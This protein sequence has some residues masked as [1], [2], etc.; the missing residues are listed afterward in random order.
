MKL[1]ELCVLLVVA[2]AAGEDFGPNSC[3]AL[4]RSS[5]G[6]CVISTD[7]QGA[8]ITQTEFAFDCVNTE[9][10]RH[11]FG[12]GGFEANEEF[13]T[14]VKCAR[15]D[16]PTGVA[17]VKAG[18]LAAAPVKKV[19]ALRKPAP[20]AVEAP[21]PV[22]Q[23]VAVVKPVP[24]VV[25]MKPKAK[26]EIVEATP[27]PL[28]F[29]VPVP[30]PKEQIP[31]VVAMRAAMKTEVKVKAKS[32]FWPFSKGGR[33]RKSKASEA[34][35]YG[36]DGCVSTY[37][38]EEGH[39]IMSTDC[40]KSNVKDYQFGLV[41]VDKTGSPVKHLFG[42]DSFD[43][44]ET[45]DTLIKCDKCLG[46]ED[47]PD[48]I[49]LAG[50]VATMAKDVASITAVMKNISINVQMLNKAVFPAA[51]APGPAAAGSP[52]PA[53]EAPKA[54]KAED[55]PVDDAPKVQLHQSVNHHKH[56][57]NLRR[58]HKHHHHH[59][60][61]HHRHEDEDDDDDDDERDDD[62]EVAPIVAA[63][64]SLPPN[65]FV[66]ART[67]P[68]LEVVAHQQMAAAS[69][70]DDEEEEDDGNGEDY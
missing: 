65:A 40:G 5:G 57:G 43:S 2:S 18:K 66:A 53:M 42:K 3:V 64:Q 7:C 51:A 54:K 32:G 17:H 19:E 58:S 6:S 28:A 22:V 34:V 31:G 47:I 27:A 30:T 14:E 70:D 4:T 56:H 12:V 63:A 44:K 24:V 49:A 20:V 45:F 50:E 11:S 39:C 36:P 61:R 8:D 48:D 67:A 60:R 33:R 29:A 25:A 23:V 55:A 38:S 13:D 1:V 9:V 68:V 26:K 41:C 59:H 35:K 69:S 21:A 46:L 16:L 62:Q 15:C 10:V 37:K 52:A